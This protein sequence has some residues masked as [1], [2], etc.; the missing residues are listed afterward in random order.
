MSVLED[1]QGLETRITQRLQ[2]LRPLVAEFHELEEA[3]RKLGLDVGGE[4]TA[5]QAPRP[6]SA[7][8]RGAARPASRSASARSRARGGQR[9]TGTR[10]RSGSRQTQLLELV[11]EQPGIT[12]REAGQ[13]LGVDSTSLYR[14]V[15]RLEQDGS[16]K[17]EGTRLEPS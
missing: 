1:L 4:G 5:T 9:R 6:A 15:H 17:K 3:A 10:A 13:R 8:G 11:K 14:V 7:R 2:E 12:V 16:V